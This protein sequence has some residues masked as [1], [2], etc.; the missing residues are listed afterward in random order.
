[1]K[2]VDIRYDKKMDLPIKKRYRNYD[3]DEEACTP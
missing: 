2:E 3:Q 1:M